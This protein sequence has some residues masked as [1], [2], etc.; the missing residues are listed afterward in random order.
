MGSAVESAVT[1]WI[2][3][4]RDVNVQLQSKPA[5]GV[6]T[7]LCLSFL[8]ASC[9]FEFPYSTLN[10]AAVTFCCLVV[11]LLAAAS[12][13]FIKVAN[14][15]LTSVSRVKLWIQL[16]SVQLGW[17]NFSQTRDLYQLS[18]FAC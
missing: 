10:G 6:V 17:Q 11:L 4:I 14:K 1:D 8:F 12:V 13:D 3:F 16:K 15:N 9:L 18:S 7:T 2:K 5:C